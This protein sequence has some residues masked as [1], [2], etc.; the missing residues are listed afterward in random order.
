MISKLNE[1]TDVYNR[2][3]YDSRLVSATKY[4]G[5]YYKNLHELTKAFAKIKPMTEKNCADNKTKETESR[6]I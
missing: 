5:T 4:P 3:E 2:E 6:R 1:L